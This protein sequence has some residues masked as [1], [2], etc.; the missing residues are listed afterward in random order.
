MSARN[1]QTAEAPGRA[2]LWQRPREVL[3][4]LPA[5]PATLLVLVVGAVLAPSLYTPG[6]LSNV[7]LQGSILGVVTIGQTLV[8]LGR[9]FDLSV[10]AVMG[11]TAT[12]VTEM[13][14]RGF[15]LGVAVLL[16]LLT[17]VIIG[18]ANG[19]LVVHRE[20]PPFI[21]TLGMLILVDGAR[22]AYTHGA[23][24]GTAPGGL[25]AIAQA[26]LGPLPVPVLIWLGLA[27]ATAFVLYKFVAGR[28][29]YAAGANPTTARLSGVPVA[30]TILGT[31]VLSA[32]F[33][34]VAGLL[35][36]GYT[37]YVDQYLGSNAELDSITAALIGGVTFAGGEGGIWGPAVGA[38][39]L[40]VLV[41]LV[42]LL[43]LSDPVQS[44]VK[45]AVLI[46]AVAFQGQRLFRKKGPKSLRRIFASPSRS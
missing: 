12:L 18:L 8:L 19:W 27:G 2:H 9:G 1:T 43:N 33:A 25:R 32:L 31:Y 42:V 3:A 4:Q 40:S 44:I 21:A 24:S 41:N 22:A 29:L 13:V 35:Q 20:V 6:N 46:T 5:V 17:G 10:G 16:A 30:G 26:N 14:S 39:L 36:A 34:V 15:G 7:L 11:L 38:L 23:T 28:W 37:G 45:G